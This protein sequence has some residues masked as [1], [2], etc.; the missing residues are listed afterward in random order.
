MG[1][2]V[3]K[4]EYRVEIDANNPYYY[5]PVE[6]GLAKGDLIVFKDAGAPV[7]FSAGSAADKVPVTDPTSDTGWALKAY[8]AGGSSGGG[9]ALITLAN[10]SGATIYAGTVVTFDE[11]GSPLDVRLATSTDG[12]NLFVSSD[13]YDDGE[14]MLCYALPN[15]VCNVMCGTGAVNVGDNVCVSSTAG[16]AEAGD[17]NT[18]GVAVTSKVSGENGLVKVLLSG[19]FHYNSGTTDLVDG[20]SSLPNGHVYFYYETEEQ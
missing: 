13:D 20:T 16:I 19:N 4:Y 3:E 14:D 10:N 7:R 17:Y 6:I 1:I 5:L 8:S 9:S 18:I 2:N 11:E 12:K 15:S